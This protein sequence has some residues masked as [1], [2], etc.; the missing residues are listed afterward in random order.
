MKVQ[1]AEIKDFDNWLKLAKEVEPLFGP[2]SEETS[3]QNAL[4]ELIEQKQAFCIKENSEFC[5]AIAISKQK[6]EILWFAVSQKHK[7]K[8]YGK[9]LLQY[10]INEL[11]AAKAYQ[12]QLK[13]ISK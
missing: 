5:A 8:G 4:K 2:M 9:F 11:D 1:I 10:A 6:N 12:K 3:F 7:G 13:K